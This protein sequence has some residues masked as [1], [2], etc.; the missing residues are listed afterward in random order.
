VTQLDFLWGYGGAVIGA[1]HPPFNLLKTDV[2]VI[3]HTHTYTYIYSV[4]H[5]EHCVSP[6]T[7]S[8]LLRP[9]SLFCLEKIL[10]DYFGQNVKYVKRSEQNEE[11]NLMYGCQWASK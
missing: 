7:L 5:L 4:Y 1:D 3:T 6:R 11:F 2:Y 8:L 10:A 9:F